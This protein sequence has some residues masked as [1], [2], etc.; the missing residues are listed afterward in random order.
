MLV[1]EDD[2]KTSETVALYLRHAG[3]EVAQAFDGMTALEVA[4]S[5]EPDL[6]ILDLMLPIKSGLEVCAALRAQT[7]V[8]IIMLS[9]RTT[10]VDRLRGLDAGADDY[11]CKPFSPREVAARVRAILRRGPVGDERVVCGA[12]TLDSA[13]HEATVGGTPLVL[14]LSEFRLL[15]SLCRASGKVRTRD[16]LI[17]EVYGVEY[18][19]TERAIDVHVR[20]LRK[21]IAEAGG[22]PDCIRTIFGVGYKMSAH[23]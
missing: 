15:F 12:L 10:E 17:S 8:P 22:P 19:G 14:T 13:S 7:D 6:V 11:V 20:N 9:A 21:K 16:D 4:A 5:F 2:A 1:V 18:T 3:Y 23:A